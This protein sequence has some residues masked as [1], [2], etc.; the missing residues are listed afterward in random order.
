M[1][2]TKLQE[3]GK[4]QNSS[5]VPKEIV[6]VLNVKKG[7]RLVWVTDGETVTVKKLNEVK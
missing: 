1:I 2:L 4:G 7:D 5:T 6:A 3:I